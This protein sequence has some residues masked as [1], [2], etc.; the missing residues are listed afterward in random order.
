MNANEEMIGKNIERGQLYLVDVVTERRKDKDSECT[1]I[2][3]QERR[4][5][6]ARER[7]NDGE[8]EW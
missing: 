5:E 7:M 2:R 3:D 8:R 4:R 1:S 6:V